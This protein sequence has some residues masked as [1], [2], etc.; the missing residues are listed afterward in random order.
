MIIPF[1]YIEN[2]WC[3]LEINIKNNCYWIDWNLIYDKYNN[4]I[5][6]KNN[7]SLEFITNSNILC[8]KNSKYCYYNSIDKKIYDLSNY[9]NI[10]SIDGSNSLNSLSNLK[11]TYEEFIYKYDII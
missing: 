10:F 11:N 5:T 3:L 6:D 1:Y 8:I 7:L 4:E 9:Y 2:S